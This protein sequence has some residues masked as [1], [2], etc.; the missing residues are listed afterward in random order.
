M[1]LRPK[2]T[3]KRSASLG[4]RSRK[5]S[6]SRFGSRTGLSVG[7]TVTLS[8]CSLAALRREPDCSFLAGGFLE[9]APRLQ[10]RPELTGTGSRCRESASLSSSSAISFSGRRAASV[11]QL[12]ARKR[13]WSATLRRSSGLRSMRGQR[14]HRL[15]DASVSEPGRP[16]G[17]GAGRS[18]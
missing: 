5:A 9:L 3:Q 2:R 8:P 18:T 6:G 10:Q 12:E 7:L 13:Q 15:V 1:T 17:A 11:M 16:S 4:R 14:L